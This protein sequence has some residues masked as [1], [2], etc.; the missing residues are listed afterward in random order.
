[1]FREH[2]TNR[3]D[4]AVG[5]WRGWNEIRFMVVTPRVQQTRRL[6]IFGIARQVHH[7]RGK[8]SSET[9]ETSSNPERYRRRIEL[10]LG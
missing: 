8:V 4:E 5:S 2:V 1:M 3:P 7:L 9:N 10:R 6:W